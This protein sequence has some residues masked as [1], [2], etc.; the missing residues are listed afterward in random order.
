MIV[1]RQQGG[2]SVEQGH[3]I[4][5]EESQAAVH[6]HDLGL[7]RR[8]VAAR[9]R[10]SEGDERAPR[11]RRRVL[12]GTEFRQTASM[13]PELGDG[14][15]PEHYSH[16]MVPGGFDVMSSTTRFTSRISLIMREAIC[17]SRSYGRRAQ[18][19]VIASLDVTA[20]MA[21]T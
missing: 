21:I 13:T 5:A 11:M 19:A 10:D 18:S 2:R 16:S 3:G 15:G 8:G 4:E 7:E 6:H 1:L 12:T 17:S 14:L 9:A 20:R